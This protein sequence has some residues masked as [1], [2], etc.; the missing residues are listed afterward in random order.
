[1]SIIAQQVN[2][3]LVPYPSPAGLIISIIYPGKTE[4]ANMLNSEIKKYGW[5]SPIKPIRMC[6]LFWLILSCY[7]L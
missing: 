5:H 1:M 4:S 7:F 2:N 3:K 6:C